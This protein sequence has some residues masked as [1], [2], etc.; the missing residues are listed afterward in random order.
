MKPP[1]SGRKE[2]LTAVTAPDG[3]I[4]ALTRDDEAP[5]GTDQTAD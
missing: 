2:Q 3:L 1:L 5:G 4:A